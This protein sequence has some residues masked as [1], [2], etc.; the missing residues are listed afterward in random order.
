MESNG[1]KISFTRKNRNLIVNEES[2][3]RR[4]MDVAQ[5]AIKSRNAPDA[6]SRPSKSRL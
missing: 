6:W 3:E 2:N 1:Q 4:N 5:T